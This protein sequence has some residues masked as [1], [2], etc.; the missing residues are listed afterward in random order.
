MDFKDDVIVGIND[1]SKIDK[2]FYDIKIMTVISDVGTKSRM[3]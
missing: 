3:H 2:I 1:S